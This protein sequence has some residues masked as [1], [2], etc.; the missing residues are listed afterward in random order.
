MS[1]LKGY[2]DFKVAATPSALILAMALRDGFELPPIFIEEI[3]AHPVWPIQS[4]STYGT[5]RS[6]F[7]G[8]GQSSPDDCLYWFGQD[9][10]FASLRCFVKVGNSYK[11]WNRHPVWNKDVKKV[12]AEHLLA[13]VNG[14]YTYNFFPAPKRTEFKRG[15]QA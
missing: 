2:G 12:L 9:G 1:S 8:I 5:S 13:E 7:R 10:L 3:P 14:S 4:V 11:L 6:D 15:L